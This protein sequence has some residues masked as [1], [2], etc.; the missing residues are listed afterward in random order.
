MKLSFCRYMKS[1][2]LT[3]LLQWVVLNLF[4]FQTQDKTAEVESQVSTATH[5]IN[6]KFTWRG[7]VTSVDDM[8]FANHLNTF[9][10]SDAFGMPGKAGRVSIGMALH[11]KNETVRS[12]IF[13]WW[14]KLS[15][16]LHFENSNR[17]VN[18][19]CRLMIIKHDR[20]NSPQF[21]RNDAIGQ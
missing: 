6:K 12:E 7:F 17:T 3:R 1:T 10:R 5:G 19:N 20:N 18:R 9:D 13:W 8:A 11:P 2:S 21:I 14:S 15:N 16:Y 4:P